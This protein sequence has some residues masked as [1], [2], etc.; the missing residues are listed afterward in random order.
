LANKT[1]MDHWKIGDKGKAE[2]FGR[3]GDLT[4]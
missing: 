3:A 2:D 4:T 1:R